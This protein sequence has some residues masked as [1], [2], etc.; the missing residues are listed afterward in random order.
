MNQA[1]SKWTW[2]EYEQIVKEKGLKIFTPDGSAMAGIGD[3]IVRDGNDC[4]VLQ[5]YQ[6]WI[7]VSERLPE[8]K[9]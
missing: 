4:H 6:P 1:S 9:G 8:K 5:A 3:W 2:E 7:P